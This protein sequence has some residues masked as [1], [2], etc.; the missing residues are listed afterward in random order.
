M[1]L[2]SSQ[3]G[4]N[5]L[6][7]TQMES[8]VMRFGVVLVNY[9]GWEDTRECLD[10]LLR[11]TDSHHKRI[12][13]VENASSGNRLDEFR[14][15]YPSVDWVGS[16][17]NT[18]WSGGN[19][20]GIR[21]FLENAPDLDFIFLLNNDTIV[22]EDI[23]EV[24][25]QGFE[26]GY[27]I[28]GPVINEYKTPEIIQTQG[29]VF[30]QKNRPMEFFSVIETPIDENTIR[31]T[32][33]DIVNGCAVCIRREVFERI[34]LIDDR[35]FLICEESDFCLRAIEAGF[36][37]GVI[38]RTGVWHKHSVTF[39]KAG[40]PIQRYY[41]TRNL[42]LL[43]SK[44]PHR[45]GRRGWFSSRILWLKM[46]YYLYCTEQERSNH[47]GA[48]AVCMGLA[49][50]L[51]GRY[52]RSGLE[53]SWLSGIF[54]ELFEVLRWTVLRFRNLGGRTTTTKPG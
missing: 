5:G 35:F 31:V 15:L 18:G 46:A 50:G 43:I 32:S 13:V 16:E 41:S 4:H 8:K 38:H 3:T 29:V 45:E 33:V 1:N 7:A 10:S 14:I 20:L 54:S 11:C 25:T 27:E 6:S 30:N 42:L 12:V 39:A 28:V 52:G 9:N 48:Q 26:Q 40:K 19:N 53:S 37:C 21:F 44:H 17:V 24:L 49:D 2:E 22:S 47:A 51:T 23:F 34:G 36:R